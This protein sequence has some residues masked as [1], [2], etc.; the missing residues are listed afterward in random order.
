MHARN[1]LLASALVSG[2]LL[3]GG[4]ASSHHTAAAPTPDEALERL[5]DGNDRFVSGRA[6]HPNQ[7]ADRREA[8]ADGQAPFA[9]ILAC[10]DSRVGPEIAFDQG[11]GDIFVVRLAGN[12]ADPAAVAS[13]EFATSALHA[14]LIVVMGHS[15]CGAVKAT[16]DTV[17]TGNTLPGH[18]PT[19]TD[20]IRPAVAALPPGTVTL[21]SATAA[22][23]R[24]VVAQLR[25]SHPILAEMVAQGK[26][27]IV[28]GVYNIESGRFQLV[29]TG[30]PG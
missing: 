16:I 17:A 30:G 23:V 18:L 6:K 29:D 7:S 2:L 26:V 12:I 28:G 13:M 15:E 24:A 20:A 10:A 8:V 14:P 9:A 5:M 19:L 1:T 22:N 4:C 27:K 3:L 21:D 11:V 25:R